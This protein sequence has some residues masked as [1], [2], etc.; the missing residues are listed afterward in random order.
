[1]TSIDK[2]EKL[3]QIISLI[4]LI[5]VIIYYLFR[6]AYF[7]LVIDHADLLSF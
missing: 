1:M 2:R 6:G 3:F 7:W 4:F 5:T